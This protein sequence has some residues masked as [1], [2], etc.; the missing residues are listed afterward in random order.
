MFAKLNASE[1]RLRT[2]MEG[3]Y[4]CIFV[5]DAESRIR[6]VNPATERFLGRARAA[7][8]GARMQDFAAPTQGAQSNE[9][10][11][12]LFQTG[13]SNSQRFARPDGSIVV[14]DISV[15]N[16]ETDGSSVVLRYH[17]R[18][19]REGARGGRAARQR[20][21]LHPARGVRRRRHRRRRRPGEFARGKRCLFGNDRVCARGRHG[22][23]RRMVERHARRMAEAGGDRGRRARGRRDGSALGDRTH[24]QGWLARARSLGRSNAR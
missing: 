6:E 5:L 16:I 17:A 21:S 24:L 15:S 1:K 2:L 13:T 10:S 23:P 20:G 8:I 18:R 14:G 22:R 12:L 11:T 9:Q 7:L 3:A 19:H 4:D